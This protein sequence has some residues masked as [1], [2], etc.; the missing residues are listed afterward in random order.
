MEK[1]YVI[2]ESTLTRIADAIRVKESSSESIALT[3]FANKIDAIEPTLED[4][5]R[6]MDYIEYPTPLDENNF[7]EEKIARCAELYAFY[8]E[9][10][11]IT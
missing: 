5:M 11:D 2:N 1:K 7:T 9:M 4:Y 3:D 10:E 8:L 6:M